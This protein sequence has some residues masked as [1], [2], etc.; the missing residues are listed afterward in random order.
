MRRLDS[1]GVCRIFQVSDDTW[2][3]G[4]VQPR[5]QRNVAVI[6]SAVAVSICGTHP[7]EVSIAQARRIDEARAGRRGQQPKSATGALALDAILAR[8]RTLTQCDIGTRWRGG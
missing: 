4:E 8:D 6:R 5:A 1:G 7:I 3:S 2:I